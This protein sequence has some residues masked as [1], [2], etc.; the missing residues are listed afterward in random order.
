MLLAGAGSSP[1]APVA[2]GWFIQVVPAVV[3]D[4]LQAASNSQPEQRRFTLSPD[5]CG[6]RAGDRIDPGR[7]P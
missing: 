3:H 7:C 5:E 1:Q 4:Q 6:F 2:K